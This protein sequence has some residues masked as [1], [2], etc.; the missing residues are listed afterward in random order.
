MALWN[1]LGQA[2]TVAQL[3]GVDAGGLIS[4]IIQAVQTVHRNREECR[5]L[6]HHVMMIGDLLQLLRQSDMMQRPKIRR[7]LDGLEDTLRQA[8]LLV[9]SCQ[10]SNI[11]YRFLMAGNQAQKFRDVR[12]RIDSY[13]RIYPLISH[14]ETRY[15]ISGLYTRTHPSG[16]QPED[17]EEALRTEGNASDENGI[18]SVE[19]QAVTESFSVEEQQQDAVARIGTS[20]LITGYGNA[21]VLP[22]RRHW[23][24]R[25]FRRAQRETSTTGP[26]HGL[27]GQEGTGEGILS[28][29]VEVAIKPSRE[30]TS[31]SRHDFENEVQIIPQLQHA[32]I[33]KLLGCCFEGGNRILVYEYMP[34]S[35]DHIIHELRAGVSIS[36]SVRFRII[37]GIAQGAAYLHQHSRL[38][39]LH[40]DLKPSNILLDSD[41]TPRISDFGMAEVLSSDEDEKLKDVLAGTFGYID[42]EYLFSNIISIKSDVYALGVTLLGV[43]IAQPAFITYSDRE[44]LPVHAWK[45]WSSGRAAELVDPLLHGEPR[46]NEILRCIQIA[47][48]CVQE[49][50]EDRP[51]MSDVLIMLKCEAITLAAPRPPGNTSI[52]GTGALS[53]NASETAGSTSYRSAE[54]MI[55]EES[56][57]YFS[58]CSSDVDNDDTSVI[59]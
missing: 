43:I 40:G 42:P 58:C 26:I 19:V 22:N 21:E 11:M 7:P 55:E 56:S 1:G 47:L 9:T 18:G 57:S 50:Q 16:A 15:F 54:S 25:L 17:S 3:A 33:I 4:M 10:Q 52:E 23:F 35:L 31:V 44:S 5:Q 13:L 53:A 24:R 45:L 59:S 2:A 37:E 30:E 6:V 51:T 29:G 46:M 27:I 32:N 48:L 14:I 39:V 12:D 41:M 8:Y 38:R 20:E 28:N 49:K 36:W 34:A